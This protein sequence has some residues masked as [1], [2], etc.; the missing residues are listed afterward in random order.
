[1]NV[2]RLRSDLRDVALLGE[3][4]RPAVRGDG[5]VDRDLSAVRL[6]LGGGHESEFD[7]DG[8]PVGRAAVERADLLGVR[9]DLAAAG[10]D[11]DVHADVLRGPVLRVGQRDVEHPPN[12]KKAIS[13]MFCQYL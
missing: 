3:R 9:P 12:R 6:D 2:K 11:G 13:Y 7:A 10:R 1:V 8:L 5:G 4:V